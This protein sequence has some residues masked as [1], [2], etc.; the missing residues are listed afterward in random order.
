ML[1]GHL[2]CFSQHIVL[3]L[4]RTVR[5][6]GPVPEEGLSVFPWGPPRHPHFH[7]SPQSLRAGVPGSQELRGGLR[8]PRWLW[9]QWTWVSPRCCPATWL[10]QRAP[11]CAHFPLPVSGAGDRS[12]L[13][14]SRVCRATHPAQRS[15]SPP[16]L[17]QMLNWEEVTGLHALWTAVPGPRANGRQLQ[18]RGKGRDRE[19][20]RWRG[21]VGQREKGERE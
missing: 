14:P 4:K 21:R 2:F 5:Y 7:D 16:G 6:R 10:P 17:R 18:S 13:S 9:T 15:L 12:H 1:P 11:Q 20:R 3:C 8:A 19:V